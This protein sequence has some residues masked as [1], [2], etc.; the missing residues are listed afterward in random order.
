M[1]FPKHC[2]GFI[3]IRMSFMCGEFTEHIAKFWKEKLEEMYK[4]KEKQ[5]KEEMTT[6]FEL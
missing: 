6:R 4:L 2:E 3:S 5:L 1:S